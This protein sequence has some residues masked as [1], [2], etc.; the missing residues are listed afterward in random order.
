VSAEFPTAIPTIPEALGHRGTAE[1]RVHKEE[2]GF[3]AFL[4]AYSIM[5]LEGSL[6]VVTKNVRQEETYVLFKNL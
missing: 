5:P 1:W 4:F 2:R 6:L 3:Q